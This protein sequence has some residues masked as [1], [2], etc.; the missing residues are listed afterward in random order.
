MAVR[1][2]EQGALLSDYPP[3]RKPDAQNFPARNRI[4]AGL[5]LGVIVIEAPSRS[6][7]LITVDF[8]AD[9]GRDVFT[10]PGSIFSAA[11][12][13]CHRLLRDGARPV[14]CADDV[15][16]ELN[17][18][19]RQSQVAVQQAL[20]LEEDERRLLALLTSDPQHIDEVAAA[21]ARPI[22]EVN[23]LLVTLELK[24][25]VRNAGAQHYTRV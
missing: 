21:S 6:G 3:G 10:V 9:Q 8:A 18:G 7:A 22:H 23:A 13:G 16:E 15:L 1:I 25:L 12:A 2:A 5:S 17:L 4:I 20:P 24:G 14:T 19:T 11:S